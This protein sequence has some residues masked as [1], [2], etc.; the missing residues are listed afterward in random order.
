MP[1]PVRLLVRADDAGSSWSSNMGCLHACTRGIAR[2]VEVMMP[3]AWVAHAAELFNA[4]PEIDIGI[5]LTL[6]SEWDNI[7]WRP[8]THAPSLVGSDG[9]FLPLL[10]PR[11]GDPRPCL[12]KANWSRSEI[13]AELRAQVALGVKMFGS[14]SHVSTHMI[15]H[16]KD[17]DP[18]I[19]VTVANLCEDFGLIDDPFGHGLPRIQG[20]PK[21][22]LDGEARA[23]SLTEDIAKLG[24]GTHIL[25]DH[26]AQ[27]SPEL[28]ATGHDG[29]EDV[30]AD[31]IGCLDAWTHPMVMECI[32]TGNVRLISYKDL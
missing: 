3:G 20:Y 6:T 17:F 16:L 1:H 32:A 21:Y 26:P 5:H 2:S 7:R 19:G 10:L 4:H 15:R 18:E 25:I 24:D 22:P 12:A 30:A 31:R 23:K 27:T 14:A 9:N 29:Y 8:L 13:T 28:N 11:D